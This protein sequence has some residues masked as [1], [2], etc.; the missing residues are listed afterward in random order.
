MD[1]VLGIR[2]VVFGTEVIEYKVV[3]HIDVS[4]TSG[5]VAVPVVGRD[6]VVSVWSTVT[7]A[8]DCSVVSWQ[9]RQANVEGFPCVAAAVS[10][11]TVVDRVRV[12][13]VDVSLVGT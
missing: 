8:C 6:T 12:L 11:D 5:L 9:L 3:R 1:T 4:V 7:C 10:T 13:T 2:T